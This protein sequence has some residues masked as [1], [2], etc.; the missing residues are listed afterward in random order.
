MKPTP[1]SH[2]MVTWGR[3]GPFAYLSPPSTAVLVYP[4][5]NRMLE[6]TSEG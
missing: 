5:A 2:K 6:G 3:G 4:L 1:L